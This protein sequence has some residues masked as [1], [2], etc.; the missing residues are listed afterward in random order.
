M[1]SAARRP[2]TVALVAVS[3]VFLGLPLAA[4]P[5]DTD[6]VIPLRTILLG[7]A[8][9][10][11]LW[12]RPH[13]HTPRRVVLAL[14]AAG[15]VFAASCLLSATPA[16]SLLGRYPRY[17]GLPTIVTYGAMV[18]IGARLLGQS[19]LRDRA[20]EL[21]AGGMVVQAVVS[22]GQLIGDP[23]QRVTG[24]AGNSTTLGVLA[25]VGLGML[26]SSALSGASWQLWAGFLSSGACLTLSASR[27][28]LV[29]AGAAAVVAALVLLRNR[30]PRWWT[31]LALGGALIV[32]ML[33]LPS[34]RTR[35]TGTS[36]FAEATVNG[37]WLLW[38]ESW[39]LFLA[40][41]LLGVGP[42]RFVDSIGS[43]H[44]PA[45]A[46]SVGPFAPPDSP[47]MVILQVLAATGMMGA[48]AI[49]AI[50]ATVLP[51]LISAAKGDPWNLGALAGSVGVGV[52]YL[53]AFTDPLTTSLT[54]V[55]V[56]G[57]IGS[58]GFVSRPRWD[59][60]AAFLALTVSGYL[61]VS[62]LMAE[63]IYTRGLHQGSVQTMAAAAA[64]RP[65]DLDLARRVGYTINRYA[66]GGK[67]DPRVSV[68]L[69]EPVCPRMPGSVE[70]LL[71]YSDALDLSGD[72]TAAL[73]Q[74]D[75]AL[76]LDP[77]NLD[78][79]LRRGIALAQM[80][81]SL[82]AETAFKHAASLR[83]TAPEPWRNLATLYRSL[84]RNAEADAAAS[85]AQRLTKK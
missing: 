17:E 10:A 64:V 85:T 54:A 49:M 45:W 8:L 82:E 18:V 41:P 70:C 5:V 59:R 42:S 35:L 20:L 40:H 4:T 32:A 9:A 33:L 47:H 79:H 61:G 78:I 37:R 27:G 68:R 36:P 29:G 55:V 84:G 34:G 25:M 43:F 63:S 76:L 7:L 24:L 57:A 81:R 52:A 21:L 71:S 38:Q 22:L 28:A 26:G 19:R 14:L 3:L 11:G 75:S 44:T 6:P 56:G 60:I 15:A 58:T 1:R 2:E 16:A 66:E 51:R 69:L 48:L 12:A 72:H 80:G 65:W 30:N 83:P 31:A 67:A 50:G 77:V 53:T 23:T 73:D 62:L 46:A 39:S 74:L 13:G